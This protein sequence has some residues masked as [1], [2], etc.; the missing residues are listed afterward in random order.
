MFKTDSVQENLYDDYLF[1]L[2]TPNMQLLMAMI[3]PGK[4]VPYAC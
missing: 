3:Y 2:Q 1:E 4:N